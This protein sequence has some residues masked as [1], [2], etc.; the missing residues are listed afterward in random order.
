MPFKSEKQR[1]WM[2]ANKPEMAKKWTK[3]HGSTPVG[4]S[5]KKEA[6]TY[7]V[8]TNKMKTLLDEIRLG[9][10]FESLPGAGTVLAAKIFSYFG[11]VM[12]RFTRAGEVQALL[13]TAPMNYESG[14]Y[15]RTIMRRACNKKGRATLY[16]YAFSSLRFSGWAREYYDM[17][18]EKGKTH[19]V[20]LRALSNKWVK[21]IFSMW[22]N[23]V[24][25]DEETYVSKKILKAA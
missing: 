14:K 2:W 10:I 13:G 18:R 8:L 4:S 11:D 1:R 20:A 15:S 3:E 24:P 5:K 7:D 19:S 9:Y 12:D 22:K 16:Y 21:I 6:S 25:Y 17:Q 23:E